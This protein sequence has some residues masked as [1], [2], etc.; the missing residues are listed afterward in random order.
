MEILF[1]LIFFLPAV[2]IFIDF[3]YFI[4]NLKTL[5]FKW[6]DIILAFIYTILF[7]FIFLI[8]IDE[9]KVLDCCIDGLYFSPNHRFSIYFLISI[10]LMAFWF[11]KLKNKLSSPIIEVLISVLLLIGLSFGVLLAIHIEALY[12]IFTLPLIYLF[13]K[14]LSL[15]FQKIAMHFQNVSNSFKEYWQVVAI[16]LLFSSWYKKY[17]ILFFLCLP[18]L[19]I[20]A[21]LTMLFGQQ[22]DSIIRAFTDTYY[23]GLSTLTYQCDNVKCGGH[24]LCSIAANGNPKIVKPKRLGIRNGNLIICNRQLLI[25]NAFENLLAE[26]L[27]LL[28]KRIRKQ[29]DKVGN[30]IHK[31]YDFY[32]IKFVSNAVYFLMKPLEWIFLFCLYLFDKNPEN[33]IEKQY[34]NYKNI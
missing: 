33:R 3:C 20:I 8:A 4:F 14:Q 19:V 10:V 7:P 16:D 25:A 21:S 30:A 6:L 17:T 22:P 18:V 5:Y 29:Y 31:N 34:T 26:K 9:G 32:K 23:H 2:L 1:V 11:S 12:L 15:N 27:P 28:H 24:Y 13:V